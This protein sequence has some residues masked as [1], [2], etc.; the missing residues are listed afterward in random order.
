MLPAAAQHCPHVGVLGRMVAPLPPGCGPPPALAGSGPAAPVEV[1]PC[2]LPAGG[3]EGTEPGTTFL[4]E[5]PF[6]C[7]LAS[8]VSLFLN[9]LERETDT[10]STYHALMGCCLHVP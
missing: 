4:L 3:G 2:A 5:S 9:G 8:V 7:L 10:V 1:G 6:R